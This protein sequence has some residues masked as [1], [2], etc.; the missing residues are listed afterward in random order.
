MRK[1]VHE[2]FIAAFLD[3][4]RR[5]RGL[6]GNA[7]KVAYAI[8][9][10]INRETREA[11]PSQD[12]L[13]DMTSLSEP[14]IK[15]LIA[16]LQARGHLHV[17]P[18]RG[19]G[20]SSRYRLLTLQKGSGETPFQ[21]RK[22]FNPDDKR[23]QSCR[24]KGSVLNPDLLNIP[25]EDLLRDSIRQPSL[26]TSTSNRQPNKQAKEATGEASK[27]AKVPKVDA[28][29]KFWA[30]YPRRVAKLA[31][32]KAFQRALR[33]ATAEVIIGAAKCYA[34]ERNGQDPKYTAHPSTWLNAG[35]WSDEPTKHNGH[36]VNLNQHGNGVGMTLRERKQLET[37]NVLDALKQSFAASDQEPGEG[38]GPPID[39]VLP[40][41]RSK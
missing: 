17:Q 19:R 26:S 12:T 36:R 35:R 14:T 15:R 33:S 3:Q 30:T 11:W 21:E 23:V 34:A 1:G 39:R 38:N 5:D 4:V 20:N 40:S 24:E 29:A 9:Q 37:R 13:I 6:P 18:G 2:A 22:G 28:F 25:C 31:A 27:P 32:E 16:A 7:F 10:Y 8:A 41:D